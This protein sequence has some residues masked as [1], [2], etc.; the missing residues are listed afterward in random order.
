MGGAFQ[1]GRERQLVFLDRR[2]REIEERSA[3][4]TREMIAASARE[5]RSSTGFELRRELD[6]LR[7]E[8]GRLRI[9]ESLTCPPISEAALEEHLFEIERQL[10]D[11]IA[12]RDQWHRDSS[13]G[14]RRRRD[15]F[16]MLQRLKEESDRLTTELLRCA[17]V[18]FRERQSVDNPRLR[19]VWHTLRLSGTSAGG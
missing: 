11:V 6:R 16:R 17:G 15:D 18:L 10:R 19:R 8:R 13:A 9:E 3:A 2:M 1:G 14:R 4:A 12:E 7:C 5:R